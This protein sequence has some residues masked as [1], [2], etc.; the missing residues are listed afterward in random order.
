MFAFFCGVL[1][2]FGGVRVL[3]RMLDRVFSDC[4]PSKSPQP[5]DHPSNA[6]LS[7]SKSLTSSGHLVTLPPYLRKNLAIFVAAGRNL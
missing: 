2:G 1:G 3:E 4:R 6:R 7:P 5:R